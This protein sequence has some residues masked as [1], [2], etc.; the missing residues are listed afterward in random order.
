MVD[1][2][3]PSERSQRMSRVRS[4]NTRAE[5]IVRRMVHGMGF[6]YRLHDAN[7]PGKPDIVFRKRKKVIF[8]HGC[9]WHRH[10]VSGCHLARLPKSRV[11]FWVPKLTAN[12]Q[13]D[14]QNEHELSKAGWRVLIIWECELSSENELT[15]RLQRFLEGDA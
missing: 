3:T 6:R 9:F 8:V 1:T 15:R 12:R 4:K 11:D 2:L 10:P 14:I 7:L 5:L 13:R